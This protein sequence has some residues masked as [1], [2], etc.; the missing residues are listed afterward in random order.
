MLRHVLTQLINRLRIER[1]VAGHGHVVLASQPRRR[2]VAVEHAAP[3]RQRR[4]NITAARLLSGQTQLP[5]RHLRQFFGVIQL[6]QVRAVWRRF[7]QPRPPLGG[8]LKVAALLGPQRH[9]I[10]GLRVVGVNQQHFLQRLHRQLIV[11]FF[12]PV[13]RLGKQRLQCGIIARRR[14]IAEGAKGQ[15]AGQAKR[16]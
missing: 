13:V 2:R 8:R 15:R 10:H 4:R 9:Q 14:G 1:L 11:R 3:G 7:R 16:G 5:L 12:M 6:L